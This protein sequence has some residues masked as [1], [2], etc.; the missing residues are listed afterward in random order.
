MRKVALAAIGA[1]TMVSGCM[2]TGLGGGHAVGGY[3]YSGYDYNRPDPAYGGYEAD[4]YYRDDPRTR[5][6]AWARTT[7]SMPAGTVAITAA[8]MTAPPA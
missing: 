4:R 5:N 8:A 2:G 3:G 1:A 7:A 6:A